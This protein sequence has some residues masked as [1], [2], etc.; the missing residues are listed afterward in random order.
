MY[1]TGSTAISFFPESTV[2]NSDRSRGILGK[3][4]SE[5]LNAHAVSTCWDRIRRMSLVLYTKYDA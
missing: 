3:P 1:G 4:H 2:T 5:D